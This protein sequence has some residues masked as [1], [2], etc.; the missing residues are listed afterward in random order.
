MNDAAKKALK[1]QYK[2]SKQVGG[3]YRICCVPSGECWV[4]CSADLKGVKNRF[5]FY[6]STNQSPEPAMAQV[7]KQYGASKFSFEVLEELEKTETQTSQE[8][9]IDIAALLELWNEKQCEG[10]HNGAE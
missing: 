4:R 7:W 5:A 3:V 2:N 1:N 6:C 10:D 9:A 8:F